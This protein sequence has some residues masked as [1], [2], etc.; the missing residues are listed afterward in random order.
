MPWWIRLTDDGVGIHV[1]GFERG[2][3]TSHGCIRCL[4]EAQKLFYDKT[5]IGTPVCIHDGKHP[6]PSVLEVSAVEEPQAVN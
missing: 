3:P 6:A 2:Q 4:E 1:G 5:K